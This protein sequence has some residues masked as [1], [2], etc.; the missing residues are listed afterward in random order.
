[1]L[2]ADFWQDSIRA[3]ELRELCRALG[4]IWT[5]EDVADIDD[6]ESKG[7]GRSR[8]NEIRL[9]LTYV[10]QPEVIDIVKNYF[11]SSKGIDPPKWAHGSEIEELYDT[12]KKSFLNFV[13]TFVSP[14]VS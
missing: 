10:V 14:K 11:G 7:K 13:R 2:F 9:P 6:K 4:V 12:D 1:M 5:R 3:A 8:P